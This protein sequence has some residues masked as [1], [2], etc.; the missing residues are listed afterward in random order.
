MSMISMCV[1]LCGKHIE[2]F[3]PTYVMSVWQEERVCSGNA[4]VSRQSSGK[5]SDQCMSCPH[6]HSKGKQRRC[7]RGREMGPEWK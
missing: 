4:V 2:N 5:T 1:V 6:C 7:H 3:L